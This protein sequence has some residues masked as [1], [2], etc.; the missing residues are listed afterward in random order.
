MDLKIGDYFVYEPKNRSHGLNREPIKGIIKR[1]ANHY[2]Y[3]Q[4]NE[5]KTQR[6]KMSRLKPRG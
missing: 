5:C 3:L 4:V 6:I 1:I 2:L